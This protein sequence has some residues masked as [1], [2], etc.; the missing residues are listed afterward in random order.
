MKIKAKK[1]H[2]RAASGIR[3]TES[4]GNVFADLGL[5]NPERELLKAQLTSQIYAILKD[6]GLPQ[7]EIA[8]TLALQQPEVALLMRNRSGSF[9]VRRLKELLAALRQ[10]VG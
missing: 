4:S 7:A 6:C 1:A 5:P 10:H 8:E 3:I 9:S 2:R